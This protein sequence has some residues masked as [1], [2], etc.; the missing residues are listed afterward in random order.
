MAIMSSEERSKYSK[1]P[2]FKSRKLWVSILTAVGVGGC[3]ISAID[4]TPAQCA[5]LVAPGVTYVLGE[6]WIDGRRASGPKA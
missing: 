5:A 6:S 3:A 2:E 1:W 4:L